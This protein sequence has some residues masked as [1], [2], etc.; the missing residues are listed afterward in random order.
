MDGS[1]NNVWY[2]YL[3]VNISSIQSP[4]Q[5]LDICDSNNVLVLVRFFLDNRIIFFLFFAQDLVGKTS[6]LQFLFAHLKYVDE[7]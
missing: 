3:F 1:K 4:D 5:F 7:I 2:W 6:L